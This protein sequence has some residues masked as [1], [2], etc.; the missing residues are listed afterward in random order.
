MCSLH[1]FDF[2]NSLTV[3]GVDDM[4]CLNKYFLNCWITGSDPGVVLQV[5]TGAV[6]EELGEGGRVSEDF[7]HIYF[8]L[9]RA[10]QRHQFGEQGYPNFRGAGTL[11]QDVLDVFRWW[12][13]LW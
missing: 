4:S 2:A 11:S 12:W 1:E 7:L 6:Q 3:D 5:L 9:R 8:G 10:D 13:R